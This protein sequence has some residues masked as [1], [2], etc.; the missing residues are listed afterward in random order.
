[1]IGKPIFWQVPNDPKAV[2]GARVAGQPLI[3]HAP[4]SRVQQSILGLAQA[5]YGKPVGR[6]PTPRKQERLGLL[7]QAL[8]GCD[9]D[10]PKRSQDRRRTPRSHRCAGFNKGSRSSTA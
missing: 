8:T 7:R 9:R 4:K 1:M 10:R 3:K 5:L 2:I 6:R